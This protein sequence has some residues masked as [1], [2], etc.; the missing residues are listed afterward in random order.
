MTS[1]AD[2]TPD[3]DDLAAW[4]IRAFGLFAAPGSAETHPLIGEALRLAAEGDLRPV[5]GQIF[6][7]ATAAE[8]HADIEAGPPWGRACS[9]PATWRAPRTVP[10]TATG[11]G[12]RG[13]EARTP[14]ERAGARE[15]TARAV[16]GI[17]AASLAPSSLSVIRNLFRDP[18]HRTLAIPVRM[19]SFIGGG[20]LGPLVGSVLLQYFW[21]GSVFL[22]AVPTVLVLLLT[23]PFLVPEFRLAGSGRLELISVA[24]SLVTPLAIVYGI[25]GLAA[26]SFGFSPL[27][28][29]ALDVLVGAAFMRRQRRLATPLLDLSLFRVPAFAVS[30]GG[31]I[32]VGML[33]LG[34]SLLISQYLQ[35]VLGFQPLKAGLWQLPTAVGGT[36]VALEAARQLPG[37]LGSGLAETARAAFAQSPHV[38]ALILIPCRSPSRPSP[39]RRAAA[40][41]GRRDAMT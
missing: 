28:F 15:W 14:P 40:A 16:Q 21:W 24:M 8:A 9:P 30:A 23:V 1:G 39:S 27:G 11:T 19:M 3:E 41:S 5:V 31:V 35:P 37:A 10:P 33:L 18:G 17:A 13:T 4:D 32:V 38:H 25:K 12:P 6:P 20:A 7:L 22:V 2:A 26:D 36:V 29:I 34:T